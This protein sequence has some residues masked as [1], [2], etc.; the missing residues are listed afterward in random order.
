VEKQVLGDLENMVAD[1]MIEKGYLLYEE[2]DTKKFWNEQYDLE[3]QP[4]RKISR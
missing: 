1:D 4:I 3:K 2:E